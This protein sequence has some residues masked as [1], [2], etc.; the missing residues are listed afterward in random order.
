MFQ[1]RVR[2]ECSKKS[3]CGSNAFCYKGS[4]FNTTLFSPLKG[5]AFSLTL[6]YVVVG[7]LPHGVACH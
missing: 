7:F 4:I 3:L 2:L 5:D 1:G 6:K